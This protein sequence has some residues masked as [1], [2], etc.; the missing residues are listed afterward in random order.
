MRMSV[1]IKSPSALLRL[2][3]L[4]F[5]RFALLPLKTIPKTITTIQEYRQPSIR[6]NP[7]VVYWSDM[8]ACYL[9]DVCC[10]ELKILQSLS[11]TQEPIE[12]YEYVGMQ[13]VISSIQFRHF[14]AT[15]ALVPGALHQS[16]RFA[17]AE[18]VPC[19]TSLDC[20]WCSCGAAVMQRT[21]APAWRWCS[22]S[23]NART[24]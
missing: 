20:S 24:S 21:A 18:M 17:T 3:F 12:K 8:S 5:Q 19:A 2:R 9:V 15:P 22:K 13:K 16:A 4:T 11:V 7:F 10:H 1:H 23:V 14:T 6:R